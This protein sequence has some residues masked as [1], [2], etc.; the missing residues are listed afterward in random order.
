MASPGEVRK[1]A[2]DIATIP[3]ETVIRPELG[4][5]AFT[6]ETPIVLAIQANALRLEEVQLEALPSELLDL[7]Q[8]SFLKIRDAFQGFKGLDPNNPSYAAQQK[9]EIVRRL[10]SVYNDLAPLLATAFSISDVGFDASR[11][12]LEEL[13]SRLQTQADE[14]KA[15]AMASTEQLGLMVASARKTLQD[16]AVSKHAE[17]FATAATEHA[18]SA[19][20]WLLLALAMYIATAL[21]GA[22]LFV[23]AAFYMPALETSQNVQLA[24]AKVLVFSVLVSASVVATR[25]YRAQM[26]NETLNRH[27]HNA[28]VTFEA[29]ANAAGDE[30]T[31][32]AVLIQATQ[33][34]FAPQHTGFIADDRESSGY[35]QI[36][37]VV[38]ALPKKDGS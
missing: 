27:R 34:I 2:H 6:A 30:T 37:E 32:S 18:T 12:R 24:L 36:L 8:R 35:P 14:A 1:L 29:F 23:R 38:R 9:I 26:H 7:L 15:A 17:V 19:S 21:F 22:V 13:T 4:P 33:C 16:I 5:L 31:K 25:V 3:T 10:Q 11:R 28:L 20:K